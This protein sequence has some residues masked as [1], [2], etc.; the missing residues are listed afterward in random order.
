MKPRKFWYAFVITAYPACADLQVSIWKLSC[1]VPGLKKDLW[2]LYLLFIQMVHNEHLPHLRHYA[3]KHKDKIN[4][5]LFSG[6]FLLVEL[7]S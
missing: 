2:N 4:Q 7:K 1:L 3:M 6:C 5:A